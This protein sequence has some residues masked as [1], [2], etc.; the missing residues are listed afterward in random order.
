MIRF[1]FVLASL[2]AVLALAT[3]ALAQDQK[4]QE[5]NQEEG[6]PKVPKDSLQV[7]VLGCLK[8]RVIRAADVRQ[9]DVTSGPT[10]TNTSF[11]LAGNKDR[12]KEVKD[13]DGQRVQIT[14]LIKKSALQNQGMKFKGGRIAVG[15]GAPVAGSP[16]TAPSPA[17]NVLV[18]DVLAV[19]GLG[20]SCGS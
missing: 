9:P 5:Q 13:N 18:M 2:I 8:G 6:K 11:R 15:G 16:G 4:P 17:E 7:V 19:E 14:G 1:R 20:G 12:M 3:P 10:I